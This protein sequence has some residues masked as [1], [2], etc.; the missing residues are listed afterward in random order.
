MSVYS[1]YN[2]QG[3][4]YFGSDLG[5]PYD[6]GYPFANLLLG[7]VEGYGQDNVKQI[8]HARWNQYE[9]FMQ[10][11]WRATRRLTLTYGMR[12]QVIPQIESQGATIGLFN[13][14]SYNGANAG[15]LLFPACRVA[16]TATGSCSVANTYA[17]NPVTGKQYAGA[18]IGLFDPSSYSST[19]YSGIDLYPQGKF[20]DTEHPQLGPRVGLAWDIFGDGK[21]ALRAAFGIFYQRSYSVDVI[22]SNNAG[23]GPMKVPPVFQAPLFLNTTLD[24]LSSATAFFGPQAFNAGDKRMPNP[25]TNNWSLSFQRDIGEGTVLEV[26]YI[27]NNAHHGQGLA[28]NLNPVA[29]GTVWSPVQSGVNSAG[30]PLGTLN[31]A[32]VNPNQPSQILPLDLVRAKIGYSGI[33]DVT[34]FTALGESNYNSLQIQLNKRFGS[35]LTFAGNYTWQK[36]ITYNHN[37]YIPDRLTKSVLNRKH[38]V[39]FNATFA[40]PSVT[41]FLG[42]HALTR[43]ALDGWRLD[44]VV[45]LFSGN[46]LGITCTVQNAPAGYPNGQAGVPNALPLRCDQVG[47]LFLPSGTSPT[48]AGYPAK[49][50]PRLWY[51][52]NAGGALSTKPAFTLPALS[53]YG[54][55]SAPPVLFWGPSYHNVDLAIH[56]TFSTPKEG[57]RTELRFDMIN[58]FNWLNLGDPNTTLTY[59]YSTGAQTNSNFGQITTQTG[60]PA[61]GQQRVVVAS[62][63]VRF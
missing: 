53:T 6:T 9:W 23:V 57:Y 2:T 18:Y 54:F 10:D 63:V 17:V 30:L 51:P 26:G 35:R 33:G 36:T 55:G 50:D 13:P 11:T 29:P 4:Y 39:N 58:A 20:F 25:T 40:L 46:P 24:Q 59:D 3:T 14:A 60:L 49:T 31:P 8:N 37:Q 43:G 41:P 48:A 52:L 15:Q 44:S 42:N 28:T 32:F 62:L 56:K 38:A 12:F 16:V 45:Q 22:A 21:T 7:T 27:G 61:T 1:V 47:N 34:K 19:P 5:N